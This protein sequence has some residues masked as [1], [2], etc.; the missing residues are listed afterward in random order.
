MLLGQIP[1]TAPISQS[2][3]TVKRDTAI[4]PRFVANKHI[5]HA[6]AR[7]TNEGKEKGKTE[8]RKA[9]RKKLGQRLTVFF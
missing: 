6:K 1:G 2:G 9:K 4:K 7:A 8:K 5:K 3:A